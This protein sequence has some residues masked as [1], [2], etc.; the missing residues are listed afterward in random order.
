MSTRFFRF[1]YILTDRLA[2]TFNGPLE[3]NWRRPAAEWTLGVGL[4]YS[5]SAWTHPEDP[6][7]RRHEET[8]ERRDDTWDP[9]A[10]PYGRLLGRRPTWFVAG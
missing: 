8:V 7:I 3:I 4:S 1:D 2:L 9:P 10:A 5:L 6:L